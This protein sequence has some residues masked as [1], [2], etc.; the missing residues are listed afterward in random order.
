MAQRKINIAVTGW[1]GF[2]GTNLLQRL[3]K[4]S[5]LKLLL[6][7]GDLLKNSDL[8]YFFNRNK[9]IDQIIHLAGA[10][11]NDFNVLYKINVLA[12]ENLMKI[13]SQR[14]VKKIIFTSS[15]AV[16]GEPRGKVSKETDELAP[17]TLYGLTKLF[18][19]EL[20]RYHKLSDNIDYTILR[21]SNVYG[22]SDHGVIANFLDSIKKKNRITIFGDGNQTR[23]FLHVSDACRAIEKAIYHIGSGT[24]NISNPGK[25]SINEIA[26]ILKKKYRFEIEYQPANNNLKDLLLD[27]KK[28][29]QKLGFRPEHKKLILSE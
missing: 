12:L 5:D 22:G 7:E 19:E 21:F 20:V 26:K 6:F 1:Q 14:G 11:S 13:A 3:K 18:A 10:F 25:I 4:N 15:G 17:N 27:T 29:S 24:F 23:N 2:I 28:A 8:E 9:K 16:Y